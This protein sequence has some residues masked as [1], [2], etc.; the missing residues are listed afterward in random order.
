[1]NEEFIDE[2]DELSPNQ[3]NNLQLYIPSEFSFITKFLLAVTLDPE[4]LL[5]FGITQ[6]MKHN[7]VLRMGESI[8]TGIRIKDRL[9]L[10]N[11][12]ISNMRSLI[13]AKCHKLKLFINKNITKARNNN[14]LK[15][16]DPTLYKIIIG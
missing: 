6:N 7:L 3:F 11:D 8:Q 16:Q 2:I 1:M 4:K 9:S 13:K 15:I 5:T 12:I 14:S 10:N